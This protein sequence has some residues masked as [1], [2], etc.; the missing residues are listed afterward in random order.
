VK[1]RLLK[2]PAHLKFVKSYLGNTVEAVVR[3]CLKGPEGF[4]LRDCD[5][6]RDVV[7]AA[8]QRAFGE[9]VVRKLGS[10]KGL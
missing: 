7:A 8:L 1:E 2:E 10:M 9:Q 4:G 3:S 6:K 5:E